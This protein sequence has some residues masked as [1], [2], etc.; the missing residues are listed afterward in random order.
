MLVVVALLGAA[1]LR[2]RAA[3]GRGG[4]RR[5]RGARARAARGRRS[6]TSTCGRTA[7][8]RCS[9]GVGRGIDALPGV[10]VPYRGVDEWTR[11]AIGAGGTLL[12]GGRR[13]ARVL[14]A[15]RSHRL[16]GRGAARARDALRGA[17]RGARTS[18]ASSCAA[19]CSRCSMVAFLRLEKLRVRDAPAAGVVAVAAAAGA[20]LAAPALD[21]ARAVVRLREL[22]ASRRPATQGGRRSAGTTTTA[23]STGR[24]TGASCCASRPRRPAY[25]KARD[26]DALRRRA[27]GARI[28]ASAARTRPRSCRPARPACARWTPAHRGHGAQ[29]ALGHASSPPG[30][31]RRSTARPAYPIGGGVFDAPDGLGRGDS[32]TAE[33]YTPSPTERAAA[34]EHRHDYE[35]WLRS[36]VA[37]YL[38]DAGATG[39]GRPT[40]ERSVPLP[41]RLARSGAT[42]ARRRPSASASSSGS[43]ERRP[44]AQR[45][46]TRL[47]ARAAAASADAPTPFEYVAAR[48]GATST[49][50]S[51]TP[52]RRRGP[53]ETLDGFLF[54]AKVG[55]CQQFSGAE[56]LLLRMGGVP[57]RVATGFS[58]GSFDDDA[59]VR[60]ARPRRPL[61]GRGVV[62]GLRLGHARPDAGR[63]AAALAAGRRARTGAA[64][65]L[66]GAPDLGGERLTRGPAP[67]RRHE[68]RRAGGWIALVGAGVAALRRGSLSSAAARAGRAPPAHAADGRARARAAPRPRD[69]RPGTTLRG[70]RGALARL[71][72]RGRGYV[73][74]L[75]EQR[76][77]RPRAAPTRA[78]RRGAARRAGRGGGRVRRACARGGRCR[79]GRSRDARRAGV[80]LAG[81][82][83]LNG[84]RARRRT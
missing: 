68:R 13:A 38:A 79:R 33:V 45:P 10:R 48:R 56:A 26:L 58:P 63:R 78:Q 2:A 42:P 11:L 35:D 30:S 5:A 62:P 69:R 29:P 60:R 59:R 28:R 27:A 44:G 77:A 36:Y 57:A 46:A 18:R 39:D 17:R 4:A 84:S 23:R 81:A 20:L 71:A 9:S 37:I 51:P 15:A 31:R 24:A 43:A 80:A 76:Y 54:D 55:F 53:R 21:G 40:D 25:W 83:C 16:P 3:L 1:R 82:S 70:A 6:P 8:A 67:R 22:G 32:Y 75:R 52:R 47:G 64:G 65:R 73:R 72:R 19:R 7:G 12:A 49:T 50:A 74:A 66:A 61:V 41:G 14:A 34:R